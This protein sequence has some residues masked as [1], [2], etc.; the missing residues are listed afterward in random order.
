MK[1]PATTLLL[2]LVLPTVGW[3]QTA[4][5]VQRSRMVEEQVEMR[6]ITDERVLEALRQV[7]RHEF[8]P[9]ELQHLAY[10]DHA[11]P[12][13]F[14]QT[15]SQPYIVAFMTERLELQP[16]HRLFE[17]GTGSGYQAAVASR[18]VE[19]VYTVEIVPELAAHAD[20][21]LKRLGYDNVHVRAGDGW[22]G[23]PEAAPFDRIIVTAAAETLPGTLL[24]QLKPGGRMILPL[25][26]QATVQHLV[27]VTKHNDGELSQEMLL[28]VR[29]VPVTGEHENE[30]QDDGDDTP[31][32]PKG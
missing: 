14:D 16:E 17:L 7:P 25:G 32:D 30:N 27:L 28:P 3:G 5:R 19:D 11:L 12:I 4:F 22:S 15:I 10:G 6:G 9:R 31:D 18:L 29:F 2:L 1:S 23:W 8:V 20:S 13:G 24:Q 21:T 26:P